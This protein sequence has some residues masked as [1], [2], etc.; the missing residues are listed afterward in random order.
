MV[1]VYF[2]G[3]S[4]ELEYNMLPKKTVTEL[5]KELEEQLDIP[6]GVVLMFNG[7]VCVHDDKIG[8]YIRMSRMFNFYILLRATTP[9]HT[10][11]NLRII[12]KLNNS[13]YQSPTKCIGCN[14]TKP[15]VVNKGCMHD[16]ILC[17][18][19]ARKLEVCPECNKTIKDLQSI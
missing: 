1:K 2:G 8:N 19:C 11:Y 18:T 13:N 5:T 3:R 7:E 10:V 4:A 9:R 16:A 14:N 6:Y 12:E 15:D 17:L